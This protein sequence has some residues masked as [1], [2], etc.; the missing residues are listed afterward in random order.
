MKLYENGAYLVNGVNVV[1]DTPEAFAQ[2][3]QMTGKKIS[4]DDAKTNTIAYGIL[5]EHNTSGNMQKL[6]IKFVFFAKK[7][8][9]FCLDSRPF[10]FINQ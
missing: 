2:I 1:L 5:K 6:Q 3:E 7:R 8:T 10:S 9:F 4:Q